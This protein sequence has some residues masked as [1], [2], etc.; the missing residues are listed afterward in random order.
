MRTTLRR[1][2]FALLGILPATIA[3][4]TAGQPLT[5]QPQSRLWINGTSTVRSFE[6][7]ATAFDAAVDAASPNAVS[8]VLAGE[9]AVRTVAVTVPA[10]KLECGNGTMNSHML[11]ALKAKEHQAIAFTLASYEMAPAGEAMQG[12]LTGTLTI[13]G[14]QKTVTINATATEGANGTLHVVGSHEVKM[15]EFGLKAPTLMMGTMKVGDK[16]KVSFDLF[17]KA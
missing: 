14:T 7:K 12:Q 13:G 5:L 16:V 8:A 3:W 2:A 4:T 11:K 15:S 10:S 6:C 1:A 9:K 17:L